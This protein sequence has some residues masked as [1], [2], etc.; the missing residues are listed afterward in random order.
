MLQTKTDA[1]IKAKTKNKQ[2]KKSTVVSHSDRF[3]KI[4][5]FPLPSFFP[6]LLP[7]FLSFGRTGFLISGP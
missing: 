2:T 1:L 5:L 4:P 6:S 3:E 7:F